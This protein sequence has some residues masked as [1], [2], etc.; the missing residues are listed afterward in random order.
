[1]HDIR[2]PDDLPAA[3]D[4]AGREGAEG[5]IV[6]GETI[7]VTHRARVSELAARHKLSAIYPFLIQ[8]GDG[9]GLMG[10][11]TVP[12]ELQ[13][14]GAGYVDKILKRAEARRSNFGSGHGPSSQKR[15]LVGPEEACETL[16]ERYDAIA[17][18][19]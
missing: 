17:S 8:V 9:G 18:G 6:I 2:S 7:F 3:F 13:R 15:N 16:V 10:Y 5:L 4:A 1:V 14:L 12:T 19:T 11:V